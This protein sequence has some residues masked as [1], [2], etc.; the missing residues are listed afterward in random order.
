MEHQKDV[1]IKKKKHFRGKNGK[2]VTK[3]IL[4]AI[5][6]RTKLRNYF[7]KVKTH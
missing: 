5:M 2:F 6:F 7:L 4:K 1:P 3:E